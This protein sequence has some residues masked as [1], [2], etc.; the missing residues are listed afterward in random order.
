MQLIHKDGIFIIKNYI[1]ISIEDLEKECKW[2]K[3]T[4]N[5]KELCRTGCFQGIKHDVISVPW[6]RCPS[7]EHQT[8]YDCSES[9]K[10]IKDKIDSDFKTNINICKIQK[11][12]D[13]KSIINPH[14]DKIIDLDKESPI[15]VIRFGATRTCILIHKQTKE[16]IKVKVEHGSLLIINYNANLIWKHGIEEDISIS[17]PSYSIVFRKSITFLHPSGYIYGLNTPFKTLNDLNNFLNNKNT[18]RFY[19]KD[20]QKNKI[21]ELYN[22]EN[23][24]ICDISIYNEIIDNCIYPF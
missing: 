21:I 19:G 20:V 13:G 14:S 10:K 17:K 18:S 5:N 22:K 3:F 11:Y 12:S 24:N 6:L 16:I 4:I 1:N 9:V 7:I 8:I 15:F 2:D 23:R